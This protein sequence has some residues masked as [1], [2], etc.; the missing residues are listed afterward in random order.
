MT[1]TFRMNLAKTGQVLLSELIAAIK[2][3]PH[4][5]RS[6]LPDPPTPVGYG[7]HPANATGPA[8]GPFF[9]SP[10]AVPYPA[11]PGPHYY[12]P[13]YPYYPTDGQ[14]LDLSVGDPEEEESTEQD[15]EEESLSRLTDDDNISADP[16]VD[17]I[18]DKCAT[19]LE[20]W[21]RSPRS[22]LDILELL[23]TTECPVNCDGIKPVLIND[24]V[25]NISD[26]TSP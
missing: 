13:A 5:D 12:M 9:P 4:K 21:F 1:Y 7:V 15:K 23:Q 20:K 10:P 18:Q 19:A 8:A 16:L 11:Y 17:P 14:P 26:M 25:K 22:H 6:D 2:S 24:Q 3:K